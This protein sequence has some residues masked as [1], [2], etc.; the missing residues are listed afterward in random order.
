[1]EATA[2]VE[3]ADVTVASILDPGGFF[4]GWEKEDLH[5]IALHTVLP[6]G[7][8]SRDNGALLVSRSKETMERIEQEIFLPGEDFLFLIPDVELKIKK[9]SVVKMEMLVNYN[10]GIAFDNRFVRRESD[11]VTS[12]RILAVDDE[13]ADELI[14]NITILE[15]S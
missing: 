10:L 7:V 1:M 14:R 2:L 6:M 5:F 9:S 4:P 8:R 13:T 15:Y 11:Y 12:F 3:T